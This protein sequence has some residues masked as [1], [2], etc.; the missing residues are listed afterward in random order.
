LVQGAPHSGGLAGWLMG[1]GGPGLLLYSV[2]DGSFVTLLPG[3]ADL[4]TL[5]LAAAHPGGWGYYAAMATA[6]S[7]LGGLLSY[8]IAAAAGARWLATRAGEKRITAVRRRG[9]G[10]VLVGAILPAP[11]PYKL[12]PLAAGAAKLPRAQ[13]LAALAAGRGLRFSF[14]AYMGARFGSRIAGLLGKSFSTSGRIGAGIA[15]AAGLAAVMWLLGRSS[16]R[17]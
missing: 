12:V 9:W 1:L 2:A 10:A 5:L 11:F 6:G 8:H 7:L 17:V 4:L 16:R 3:G 13:F 14:A 15:A